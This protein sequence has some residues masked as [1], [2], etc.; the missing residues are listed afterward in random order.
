MSADLVAV[1]G[2]HDGVAVLTLK[3]PGR[4][5]ALSIALRD[6]MSDALDRLAVD[7]AF[8]AL[9][10]TGEGDV[11]SAGFDL[12]EFASP[13]LADELWASSDRWHRSLLEF[14]LP[15][16]AAVNGAAY[17]GG[18]DLAV[19]CDLRVAATAARFAHPEHSFSQVVYGPLHDLVG[20]SVAR[21]L[22]L[23]GRRVDAEE[24]HRLGIVNRVVSPAD[25]L[26]EARAVAT[27]IALAPREVLLAMIAKI[28][29][30][31]GITPGATLDL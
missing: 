7:D 13:E 6:Q 2:P 9:V 15:M 21:D 17:G 26:A 16:V 12:D 3:R 27:E 14:P 30:R 24:A 1:T 20:G 11:F 4:K 18:F 5:N 8:H 23:T 10:I 29:R 31:A 22:A 25:L 19:M 28:R